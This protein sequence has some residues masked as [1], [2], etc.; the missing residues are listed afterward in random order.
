VTFLNTFKSMT[1]SGKL[2]EDGVSA[3]R[4]GINVS[5]NKAEAGVMY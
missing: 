5:M 1:S 2:K 4:I 3:I